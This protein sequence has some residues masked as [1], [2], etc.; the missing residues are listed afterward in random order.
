MAAL[1]TAAMTSEAMPKVF[2]LTKPQPTYND[3]IGYG[4]DINTKSRKDGDG[5]YFSIKVPDG[6]YLVTRRNIPPS[7]AS[8]PS[9]DAS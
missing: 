1:A 9:H 6:N 2:D 8:E 3:S 4:Y 5:F 7:P